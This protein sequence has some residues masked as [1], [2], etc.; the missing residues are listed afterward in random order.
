MPGVGEQRHQIGEAGPL[1]DCDD[2]GAR[3]ADIARILLAEMEEV[4]DHLAFQ[5]RQVALGVGRGIA[6]VPVDRL[7]QLVAQRILGFAAEDRALQPAPDAAFIAT[8]GGA[9]SVLGQSILAY[10]I[11]VGDAEAGQ[12]DGFD[13]LHCLCLDL[14][15]M[16]IA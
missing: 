7:L 6:L 10:Q 13:R 15:L 16:V 5:R 9:T 8:R 11:G 3:H 2:V 12:N 4:A 14:P 1:L